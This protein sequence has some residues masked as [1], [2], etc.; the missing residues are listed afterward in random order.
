MRFG[1][2]IRPF[3]CAS[4]EIPHKLLVRCL[5]LVFAKVRRASR[6]VRFS[7]HSVEWAFVEGFTA[8]LERAL[9]AGILPAMSIPYAWSLGRMRSGYPMLRTRNGICGMFSERAGES[10]VRLALSLARKVPS[11]RLTFNRCRTTLRLCVVGSIALFATRRCVYRERTSSAEF[12]TLSKGPMCDA[13]FRDS[14]GQTPLG[15]DPGSAPLA[16][17][18]R[19]WSRKVPTLNFDSSTVGA[20]ALIPTPIPRSRNYQRM[21]VS[22]PRY[23][24]KTIASPIAS[25]PMARGVCK[26]FRAGRTSGRKRVTSETALRGA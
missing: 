23:L 4:N 2:E 17:G 3:C 6:R 21:S 11:S 24:S 13:T 9:E 22:P 19:P 16:D 10:S 7:P 25:F 12:S 15:I 18:S 20:V 1:F 8:H 26:V 5:P 14:P